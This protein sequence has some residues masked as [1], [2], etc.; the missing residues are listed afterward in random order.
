MQWS[1]AAVST[2]TLPL[3]APHCLT[4]GQPHL[5]AELAEDPGHVLRVQLPLGL[6]GG[7]L[8]R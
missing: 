6:G 4:A 7:F 3:V 1:D 2:V 5:V 8:T